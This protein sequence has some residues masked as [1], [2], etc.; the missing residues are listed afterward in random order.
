MTGE[1][2]GYVQ[3]YTGDGKGKTTAALGLCLRAVGA[4]LRVEMI[5]FLKKG[6]FSE[7]KAMES[8]LPSV[9]VTQFGTGRFVRG[10]P[11]QE[12]IA[13]ARQGLARAVMVSSD[14]AL[15]LLILDESLVALH[16]GLFTVQEVVELVRNRSKGLELVLTGRWCPQQILDEADLVTRMSCVKH[17]YQKGVPAREGIEK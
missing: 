10:R 17:Y 5:Q 11:C 2:R 16:F 14:P 3:V 7:I 9:K 13:E 1:K 6:R 4:G 12:D 8:L 15:D